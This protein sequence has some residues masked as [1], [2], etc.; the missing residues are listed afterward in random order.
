MMSKLKVFL[1]LSFLLFV[2][3]TLTLA[4]EATKN[5]PTAET[6]LTQKTV[7]IGLDNGRPQV[8]PDPVYVEIDREEVVW[9]AAFDFKIIFPGESPFDK[10]EFPASGFTKQ[11]KSGTPKKGSGGGRIYRY[12]VVVCQDPNKPG[13]IRVLDPT[14]RPT[15]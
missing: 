7:T 6:R 10:G 2:L 13:E 12:S 9:Q 5:E 1:S 3:S 4:Q 15:P 14:V 11:A 8:S